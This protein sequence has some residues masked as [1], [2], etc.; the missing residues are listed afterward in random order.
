MD[1]T[2]HNFSKKEKSLKRMIA[3]KKWDSFNP[4]AA[5]AAIADESLWDWEQLRTDELIIDIP[6]HWGEYRFH[7]CWQE[8]SRIFYLACFLD[9][10]VPD[11]VP[12]GLYELLVLV[13]GRLWMGHFDIVDDQ[14]IAFRYA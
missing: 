1:D 4:L 10:K 9:V 5:A 3:T 2:I 13:N 6:G 14:W 11:P 8:E 12:S 7:L